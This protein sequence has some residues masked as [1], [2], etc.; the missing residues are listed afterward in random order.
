M[1]AKRKDESKF[2]IRPA[3][4]TNIFLVKTADVARNAGSAAPIPLADLP[5][6]HPDRKQGMLVGARVELGGQNFELTLGTKGGGNTL[7]VQLVPISH[8]QTNPG[9]SGSAGRGM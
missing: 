5:Q 6:D 3:D 9:G 7:R 4:H 8:E 1:V 2:D